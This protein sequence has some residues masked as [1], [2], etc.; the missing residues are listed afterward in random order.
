MLNNSFAQLGSRA[1]ETEQ[2][3]KAAAFVEMED[4]EVEDHLK[5]FVAENQH[6]LGY[7]WQ[8]FFEMLV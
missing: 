8:G 7:E 2:K 4:K 6:S 5:L 3:S 1:P